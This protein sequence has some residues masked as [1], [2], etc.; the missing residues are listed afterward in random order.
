[1]D[2]AEPWADGGGPR[3]RPREQQLLDGIESGRRQTKKLEDSPETT[4][5]QGTWERGALE[6]AGGKATLTPWRAVG[7]FEVASF[8]AAYATA[9]EPEKAIDLTRTYADGKLKWIEHPEWAD[10][11]AHYLPGGFAAT[12]LYRTIDADRPMTITLS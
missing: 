6:K 1:C 10:G 7:P 12:Y 5:A 4:A 8:D 3:P 11:K 2:D 9:F